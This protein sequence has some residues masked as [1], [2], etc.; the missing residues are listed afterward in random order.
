[1]VSWQVTKTQYKVSD[2]VSW[3]RIGT[4]NLSPNFQRRH[5]WK[6]GAKS[7]FVDTIYRGLPVPIIF[8]RDQKTDWKSL[9]SIREVVDGQQRIR[10]LLSYIEPSL[11]SDFNASRDAFTVQAVHNPDLADKSF[12]EL[13]PEL[14][15]R[16]LDYQFSV[17]ILPLEVD[18]REVLQIFA[19]MNATGVKLNPQELRNA[20]YFGQFKTS[21]YQLA[22]EQLHRW[23]EWRVFTEDDIARML[24]VELTSEFALL[25]FRGITQKTQ[26]ALNRIYRE[27][28]YDFPERPEVEYRFGTVMET[29]EDKFGDHVR[30]LFRTRGRFFGLFAFVYDVQFGINDSLERKRAKSLSSETAARVVAAGQKLQ[31][32]TAPEAVLEAVTRRTTHQSSRLTV[33]EYLR[34]ETQ[35]AQVGS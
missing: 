10:T 2:F 12:A 7:Y 5:V 29:I 1:M 15:Q 3:Q 24:E 35:Y 11:L 4:L 19:R 18:D 22:F 34:S 9:E 8:L 16:I 14:R 23:R 6:P 13:P 17:H 32:P 28:E 21:M 30:S 20:E 26:D 27:R 31:T 33:L 25:M